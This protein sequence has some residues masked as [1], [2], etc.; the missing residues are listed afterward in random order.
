MSI[1]TCYKKKIKIKRTVVHKKS[2]NERLQN[3][4][5][6]DCP[7]GNKGPRYSQMT[8]KNWVQS[9]VATYIEFY[10]L[11][12]SLTPKYSRIRQVVP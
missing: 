5:T 9:M 10:I 11:R 4:T 1:L 7:S 6:M 8:W 12:V 2:N 3:Q